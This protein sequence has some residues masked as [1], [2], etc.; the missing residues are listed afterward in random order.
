M[1][2][3]FRGECEESRGCESAYVFPEAKNA[4]EVAGEG[5]C[6]IGKGEFEKNVVDLDDDG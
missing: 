6:V 2:R 3:G 5:D 4:A 1:S